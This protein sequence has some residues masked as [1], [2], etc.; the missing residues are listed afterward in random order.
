ML[1]TVI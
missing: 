1:G